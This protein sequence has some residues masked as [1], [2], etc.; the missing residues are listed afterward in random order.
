MAFDAQPSWEYF[1]R[2]VNLWGDSMQPINFGFLA[3]VAVIC[4]VTSLSFRSIAGPSEDATAAYVNGDYATAL[5]L[6]QELAQQGDASAQASLG[7]MYRDGRGVP[8]DNAAAFEWFSKAAEQGNAL[9]QNN[10]G[11]MYR[12]GRGVP[13]DDQRAVEWYRKA[14]EQG[15]A[16]AQNN[17]GFMY[18]TGRGVAKD[19][20]L[21]ALWY[22]K[23][24]EQ[25]NAIA[26]V[27]LGS[28]YQD[29]RG[30]L[31]KD[32]KQ[33]VDWYRKAAEQ[34]NAHAQSS[35]GLMYQ[36]GRGGLPRDD[37]QAVDWYRKAAE[38]GDANAQNALGLM[39][40]NGRG[41]PRDDQRAVEWYRKAAAQGNVIAQT[42]LASIEAA[43]S[44]IQKTDKPTQEREANSAVSAVEPV[45]REGVDPIPTG[46]SVGQNGLVIIRVD[47]AR[48]NNVG[49][50]SN[51]EGAGGYYI[52]NL[53]TG[54][55]YSSSPKFTHGVDA[56]EVEAGIYCLDSVTG[57]PNNVELQYCREPFFTVLP[58]KVNNAGW[59]RIGYSINSGPAFTGTVRLVFGP[60]Y[61]KEVFGDAKKYE[62]ELLQKYGI[63]VEN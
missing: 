54:H 5:H 47:I 25:G 20:V 33:A 63:A 26:Q 1:G 36:D 2:A 59:W 39:Y 56:R 21:A 15:N 48:L 12:S 10:L 45:V 42:L 46:G 38:Q 30:G 18:G 60:K 4:L 49:E 7:A 40:Q 16:S 6:W 32:D 61:F 41:V 51:I 13:Q 43:Q 24:A 14:A 28:M 44:Q 17:M 19:D 50:T 57:G 53:K 34:G 27:N 29:G 62:K 55:E 52:K 31:L 9:A 58:G 22:R 23:S 37:K 11:L 3:R 8:R 35:L